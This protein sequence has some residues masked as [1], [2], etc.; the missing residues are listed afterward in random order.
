MCYS[1]CVSQHGMHVTVMNHHMHSTLLSYVINGVGFKEFT[2]G[3]W[4]EVILYPPIGESLYIVL[5]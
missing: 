5:K 2:I 3:S 1:S 4:V